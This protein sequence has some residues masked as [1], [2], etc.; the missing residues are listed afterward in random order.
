MSISA[1]SV[2]LTEWSCIPRR[3]ATAATPAVRQLARPGETNSTGV[4][5]LLL[6]AKIFGLSAS[7]AKVLSRD[8]SAPSPKNLSIVE[9][10]CV[11]SNH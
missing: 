9:R 5:A 2:A 8:C 10:L 11:P 6:D 7:T 3:W 1:S 4:G